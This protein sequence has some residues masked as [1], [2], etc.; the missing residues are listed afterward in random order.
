MLL[1]FPMYVNKILCP[2]SEIGF[3]QTSVFRPFRL[4][5]QFNDQESMSLLGHW[6]QSPYFHPCKA[7]SACNL[8][9]PVPLEAIRSY[10]PVL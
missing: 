9:T 7:H 1:L 4:K 3:V 10:A 2:K 5:K 8:D 6:C